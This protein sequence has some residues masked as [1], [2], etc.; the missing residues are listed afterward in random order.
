MQ[1]AGQGEVGVDQLDQAIAAAAQPQQPLH[2][3]TI[4]GSGR[5]FALP[6]D[7]TLAEMV[8]VVAWLSGHVH[9]LTQQQAQPSGPVLVTPNGHVRLNPGG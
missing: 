4:A 8:E 6:P 2:P 5:I 9:R 7:M 3:I 1:S